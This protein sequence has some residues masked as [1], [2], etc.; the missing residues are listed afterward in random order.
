MRE[1]KFR[2]QRIDTG[3]WVYGYYLVH[4]KRKEHKIHYFNEAV[5]GMSTVLVD[6]KTVGEYSDLKDKKGKH[7][8]EGD[9]AWPEFTKQKGVIVF[10]KGMFL[11]K[12]DKFHSGIP[13]YKSLSLGKSSSNQYEII[14]N[15]TENPELLP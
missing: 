11:F 9:I 10:K 7:F 1:I 8:C 6:P 13:L 5:D 3:E 12:K 15:T 4:E 14:G 2:G